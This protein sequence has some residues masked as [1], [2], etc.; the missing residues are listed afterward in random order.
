MPAVTQDSDAASASSDPAPAPERQP[1]V[2]GVRAGG[3][4]AQS[5]G[6][7]VKSVG[8]GVKPEDTSLNAWPSRRRPATTGANAV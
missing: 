4:L 1:H 7:L 2:P 5:V 8:E 3:M 6:L